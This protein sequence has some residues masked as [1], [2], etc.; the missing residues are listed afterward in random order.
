MG[1]SYPPIRPLSFQKAMVFIDGTNLFHRL[2]ESN[3]NLQA[4]LAQILKTC[5]GGRQIVR[6]YL[7]TIRAYLDRAK[8]L[9][10]SRISQEIRLIFGEGIPTESGQIREKG[11][12]A[13]LVADLVYHAAVRNFDYALVVST[14]TDF[15]QALHRVEDFGCRTGVLAVCTEVPERL[16]QACDESQTLPKDSLLRNNWAAVRPSSD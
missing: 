14:D 13:L 2:D 8:T 3:L 11:V 1:I 10:G 12:D 7:Y 5:V 15:V 16:A 4:N 9:H 6:M